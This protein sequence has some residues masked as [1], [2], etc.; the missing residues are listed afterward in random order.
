MA[1]V[2]GKRV[3]GVHFYKVKGKRNW[4]AY[5]EDVSIISDVPSHPLA[6]PGRIA[7]LVAE[8]SGDNPI[9][10]KFHYCSPIAQPVFLAIS[11]HRGWPC[12]TTYTPS[13]WKKMPEGWREIFRRDLF[14]DDVPEWQQ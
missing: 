12:T 13:S 11:V 1:I 8:Y 3:A 6:G 4:V 14:S 9:D 5:I 7:Y 10:E 2:D